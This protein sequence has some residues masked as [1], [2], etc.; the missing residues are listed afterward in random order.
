MEENEHR[1]KDADFED[2]GERSNSVHTPRRSR[3]TKR[4]RNSKQSERFNELFQMEEEV[5]IVP[6]VIDLL[7]DGETP[8]SNKRRRRRGKKERKYSV[9]WVT[10]RLGVPNYPDIVEEVCCCI[11]FGSLWFYCLLDTRKN[12]NHFILGT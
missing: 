2:D 8:K 1:F 6:E 10:K 7:D 3:K 12:S 5:E 4:Q 11:F 9:K